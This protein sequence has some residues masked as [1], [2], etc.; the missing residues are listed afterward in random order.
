MPRIRTRYRKIV[1]FFARMLLSFLALDVFL[2]RIGL[3]AWS[4]R[5]RPER[6]RRS[7]AAFRK[8][9]VEMGGVMIKVGQFLSTRVDVLPAEVTG[10]LAGLQDEVPPVPFQEIRRVAEIDLGLPLEQ[11][12]LHFDPQPLA[13]ASL[14]QAHRAEVRL[15]QADQALGKTGALY[16][17][18][19]KIQRPNIEQIIATDLAALRT[20]GRWL[21][22]YPAIRRRA[23]VP[24][25][26]EEF[27]RV[28]YEEIDYLAEGRNAE[29]F[30]A[31]FAGNRGVRVP[32]VVW[33]HTTTRVLTLENVWAIKITDYDAISAAGVDRREVASRLLNTY[34]K[35]IFEDGFFHA[36]PHPGN[37][38]VDPLLSSPS[39]F[40]QSNGSGNQEVDHRWQLTFVDFGMVGRLSPN[41]K[42]GLRELLVG[43]GTRDAAMVVQAYEDLGV[44]LPGADLAR[45]EQAEAQIFDRFWGKNMSELRD[46]SMQDAHELAHEYRDLIY[47]MPFQVPQDLIYLARTVGI[48]SGMCTGLDPS[49]NLWEHLVPYAQKL[50]S[51]E[52]RGFGREI[53]EELPALART[54]FTLPRHL[55]SVL[56]KIERGQVAVQAPQISQQIQRL[57][58][59]VSQLTAGAVFAAFLLGGVQLWIAGDILFALGLLIGAG[60]DMLWMIW[61]ALRW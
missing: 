57:E 46:M 59:S 41:L 4:R 40:D 52:A 21:H 35:Q 45:I 23:N 29:T 16:D 58:H 10:E 37:L 27:S 43:V 51:Q 60:L 17:V 14:G 11:A 18:V 19:V 24:A 33:T 36:D 31:D 47:E 6:M 5:T 2:P 30:A 3:R 1:T 32:K 28:L 48:L 8:L 50:V 54:A 25:L 34:L 42:A 26:L 7:A 53:L 15:E 12:Y 22:R 61:R 13:A 49:F 55:D 9:A 20:V 38:F 44:L 39:L 56:S